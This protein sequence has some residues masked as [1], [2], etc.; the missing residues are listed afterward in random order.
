MGATR[1]Q[2][3]HRRFDGRKASFQACDPCSRWVQALN[4]GV[5]PLIPKGST[6]LFRAATP[7]FRGATP[8]RE[9]CNPSFQGCQPSFQGYKPSIQGCNPSSCTGLPSSLTRSPVRLHRLIRSRGGAR[10][11]WTGGL[12]FGTPPRN[13]LF[14]V[15]VYQHIR[16]KVA[17]H[18]FNRINLEAIK[19]RSVTIR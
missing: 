9:E 2:W 13:S 12:L 7:H 15:T 6:P 16:K 10:G 11:F 17:T 5:Q 18:K 14:L 3:V 4:S 8:H 19:T 1:P